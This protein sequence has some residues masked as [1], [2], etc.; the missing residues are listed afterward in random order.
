MNQIRGPHFKKADDREKFAL[1]MVSITMLGQTPI[2]KYRRVSNHLYLQR[3]YPVENSECVQ[4][5]CFF[6]V[7]AEMPVWSSG[8]AFLPE[9]QC[10]ASGS[11]ML[12]PTEAITIGVHS[13]VL[14]S[15]GQKLH[16]T[17]CS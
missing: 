1:T 8:G 3:K 2:I 7:S 11:W 15:A 9:L 10:I 6:S 4:N 12:H 5:D 13:T 17:H 14:C 16:G